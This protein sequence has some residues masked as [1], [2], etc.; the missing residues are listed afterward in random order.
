M[1]IRTVYLSSTFEDLKLHRSTVAAYLRKLNKNVVGME[2][3]IA[4][5]ERPVDK[6]L[7]DVAR[8]DVYVGLIARRY[9]FVPLTGNQDSR[10]ITEL[11]Y[12]HAVKCGK[13]T[14]IF[15]LDP[16]APWPQRSIDHITGENEA[17]KRIDALRAELG[18]DKTISFFQTPTEAG[19]LVM[20]AVSKLESAPPL[21]PEGQ[22]NAPEPRQITSDLF[23]TYLDSDDQIV[24]KLAG[25]LHP[26]PF[27]LSALLCPSDLFASSASA[28]LA[29]DYRVHACDVAVVVTT[30]AMLTR[31]AQSEQ[32]VRRTLELLEA[33]TG[34]VIGLCTDPA[35]IDRAKTWPLTEVLD[36]SGCV[37][38]NLD[39]IQQVKRTLHARLTPS[40]LPLIGVPLVVAAMTREEAEALSGDPDMIGRELGSNAQR[41][42]AQIRET[43]PPAFWTRY[44]E[45]RDGWMSPGS[46]ATIT[47]IGAEA[48]ERLARVRNSKLRGR[49]VKLQRYPFDPL[50]NE[51]DEMR[52]VYRQMADHGCIMLVDE[53]SLFHP[54][55]RKAVAT[56]PMITARNAAILTISPFAPTLP[57]EQGLLRDELKLQLASVFDRFE[58]DLDPQCEVGVNDERRLR[59][60]LHTTLPE[61]LQVLRSPRVEPAQIALFAKELLQ[62][63]ADQ[64]TAGPPSIL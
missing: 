22:R 41:R 26:D 32:R 55:V 12:R 49:A 14:L 54:R 25:E 31:M 29:V 62:A 19:A 24:R 56:C 36:I 13:P 51:I 11:E 34:A 64:P 8:A 44:G 42:F 6:C 3:Y 48:L 57:S 1:Q 52:D 10:S 7:D 47:Q 39:A 28:L 53:L 17:G 18:A 60:W 30:R 4:A 21:P 45:T 58:L 63:D 27:G 38:G 50:V 15:L 33:R 46:G 16:D 37:A 20:A 9:G 59:R 35:D 43:L 23:V 5:D 40:T 61:T 2:D